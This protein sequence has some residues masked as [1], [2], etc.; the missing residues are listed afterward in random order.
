MRDDKW[1]D[2]NKIYNY[3][4][5]ILILSHLYV[6]KHDV[7]LLKVCNLVSLLASPTPSWDPPPKEDLGVLHCLARALHLVQSLGGET[8][9]LPLEEDSTFP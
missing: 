7:L 4:N 3:G 1:L 8:L 6:V 2:P 9:V 5:C